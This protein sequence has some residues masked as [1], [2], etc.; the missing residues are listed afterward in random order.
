MSE[1]GPVAGT[2]LAPN[3]TADSFDHC[4]LR[5]FIPGL[6]VIPAKERHPVLDM[7]PESRMMLWYQELAGAICILQKN[8]RLWNIEK[9]WT[10]LSVWFR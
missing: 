2:T 6:S 4:K 1:D 10:S 8:R 3:A 9:S 7:G 5:S